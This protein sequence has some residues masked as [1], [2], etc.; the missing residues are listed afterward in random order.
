MGEVLGAGFQFGGAQ[1]EKTEGYFSAEIFEKN[2][3]PRTEIFLFALC[4]SVSFTGVTEVTRSARRYCN[5]GATLGRGGT[6]AYQ[7][8]SR[9]LNNPLKLL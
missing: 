3:L 6:Q 1:A 8:L 2:I 7:A 4:G 9:G 5:T